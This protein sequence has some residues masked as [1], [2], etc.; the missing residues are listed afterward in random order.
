MGPLRPPAEEQAPPAADSAAFFTPILPSFWRSDCSLSP[1]WGQRC[2]STWVPRARAGCGSCASD[3]PAPSSPCGAEAALGLEEERSRMCCPRWPTPPSRRP[4]GEPR[5]RTGGRSLGPR[6]RHRG[7]RLPGAP[8][9]WVVSEPQWSFNQGQ[10]SMA[11]TCP[12]M[13]LS[14]DRSGI[15]RCQA[16]QRSGSLQLLPEPSAICNGILGLATTLRGLGAQV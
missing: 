16:G 15:A 9:V 13:D 2:R 4:C 12:S 3:G 14:I 6:V 8:G 5:P 11:P 10:G 7:A 1:G